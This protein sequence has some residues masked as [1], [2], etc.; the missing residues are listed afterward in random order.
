[1][2]V[3]LATSAAGAQAAGTTEHYQATDTL[4]AEAEPGTDAAAMLD[5]FRWE[6]QTF[7]VKRIASPSETLQLEGRLKTDA[8]TMLTF[9][10]PLPREDDGEAVNTVVLEW[11]AAEG[12]AADASA[13]AVLVLD[14]LD[15]RM[16]ISRA[17][18]R[19]LSQQG[20]H[21]FVMHMPSYGLRPIDRFMLEGELFFELCTQAV[22]DARRARDVIAALPEV[23][24]DRISIQ[25][26]SLG[27]FI[28]SAAAAVDPVFDNAFILLAGGNL[29][30][31]FLNGHREAA[32]IREALA[33]AGFEGER[34]RELCERIEP[35]RLAHRLNPATTYLISASNDQV[36]PAANARALAAAASLGESNHLWLAGDHYS[37]LLYMPSAARMMIDAIHLPN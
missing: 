13:P 16:L 22:A 24:D 20:I 32:S 6:R 23:E 10:S 8:Q 9:P 14:I 4:M 3:A 27:G 28:A 11:F 37:V 35:T 33:R 36:V 26:T 5:Q 21:A 29:Y 25:G 12:V 17:F 19:A 31:M 2:A 7:D 1:M 34:L 18:A 15:G 30:E